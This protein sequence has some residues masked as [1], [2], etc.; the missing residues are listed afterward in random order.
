MPLYPY[1]WVVQA[2]K[3]I[4]RN[5]SVT[6]AKPSGET[7]LNIERLHGKSA[8]VKDSALL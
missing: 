4:G 7:A 2:R 6:T 1:F 3:T 5:F 8:P